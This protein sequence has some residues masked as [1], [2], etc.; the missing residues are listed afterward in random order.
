M[1]D[2][3]PVLIKDHRLLVDWMTGL[4][5]EMLQEVVHSRAAVAGNLSY[6]RK[7]N[8]QP[9]DVK[10]LSPREEVTESIAIPC[11]FEAPDVHSK[12]AK[13]VPA[14]NN[15]LS[16][17]VKS[18]IQEYIGV[19]SRL[20]A[21]NPFNNFEHACHVVL[22]AKKL[23]ARV[24][25]PDET[26]ASKTAYGIT[27]DPIT[28]FAIIFSALIHDVDHHGVSNAQLVKEKSRIAILYKDK[29]VAEQ[30]SIT[31]AWDL[32]MQPRFSN[33]CD[34]IMS[35]D[36]ECRLFR[37]LLVNAGKDV[38]T[39]MKFSCFRSLAVRDSTNF[40]TPLFPFDNA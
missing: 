12:S 15:L 29:S 34:V 19:I 13:V 39:V 11:N 31:I 35:N 1:Q 6:R 18:Q 16:P 20:Y 25:K 26:A 21:E 23:L 4:F 14:A 28:Q 7:S 37:Q 17:T 5:E 8:P 33:F 38:L 9:F 2:E 10:F 22:V 3:N 27:S 32:L 36:A 24:V 40:S 30:N